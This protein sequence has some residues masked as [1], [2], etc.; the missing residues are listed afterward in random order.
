LLYNAGPQRIE[1]EFEDLCRIEVLDSG[2]VSMVVKTTNLGDDERPLGLSLRW[3]LA[4]LANVLRIVERARRRAG[5]PDAEYALDIE[6]RYD[7]HRPGEQ[8]VTVATQ[9][10]FGLLDDEIRHPKLLGP[11]PL[12]LPRYLVSGLET[13]PTVLKWVVD[14][15]HNAVHRPHQEDLSFEQIAI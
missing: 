13:F 1:Q 7:A 6:L 8:P 12:R 9:Y 10:G 3:I 14:D 11:G 4:D 2:V 5:S 15:L